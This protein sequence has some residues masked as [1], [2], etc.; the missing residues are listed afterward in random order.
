M[1]R[2][3]TSLSLEPLS[4][5]RLQSLEG[6]GEVEALETCHLKCF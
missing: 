5:Y 3:K 4:Q 1:R 6:Y 2:V